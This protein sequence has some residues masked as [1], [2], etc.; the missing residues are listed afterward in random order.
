M[1]T[2]NI[3][4]ECGCFKRSEFQNNMQFES[5]DDALV[6]ALEMQ[7]HMNENFCQKH[8]FKLNEDGQNFN[9]GVSMKPRAS[10]GGC[11]GGGHCS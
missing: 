4:N 3:E 8:E 10:S 7:N 1:F 5:K 2:I 6:Q 11:C 9:I